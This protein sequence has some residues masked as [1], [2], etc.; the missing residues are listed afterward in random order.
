MSYNLEYES[1]LKYDKRKYCQYYFSLLRTKHSLIVT[2][3][4]NTDYNIKII[5]I[6]LFLFN[7]SLFFVINALFFNDDTMH[8]INEN[9]GTLDIIG[10]LHQ[11]LYSFI[12]SSLICFILEFLAL[13]EGIILV[14][15]KIRTKIKFN[16]IIKKLDKK[17]K[18]KILL[19]FFISSI[20]LIVF[21]YYLSMFCAIYVNTQKHLISD[22][23]SS[24]ILSLIEP[25]GIYLIPGLFRIPALSMQNSKRYIYKFSQILQAI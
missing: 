7:F 1:A 3:F 18:I 19:Y 9:K 16:R 10:Q 21:W 8:I 20:F 11:I 17:I 4:N 24:F 14:L 15:K 22:T 13:T 23:I 12:I 5:K 25:F 6:D 2:F